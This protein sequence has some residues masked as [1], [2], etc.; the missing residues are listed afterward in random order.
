[1]PKS[2]SSKRRK[3]P[4]TEQ[5][6]CSDLKHSQR[7]ISTF[8]TSTKQRSNGIIVLDGQ[9]ASFHQYQR[10]SLK[11]GKNNSHSWFISQLKRFRANCSTALKLLDVGA[12]NGETFQKHSHWIDISCIDL[13]PQSVCVVK[14]DFMARPMPTSDSGKFHVVSLSLVVNFLPSNS[15][16]G[17]M[18]RRS[19]H[20]LLPGGLLYVVLPLHCITN[21]RY[22]THDHFTH[23]VT[24]GIGQFLLTDYRFSKKLAFYVFTHIPTSETTLEKT[25]NP[26][27]KRLLAEG[28]SMNNFC[29]TLD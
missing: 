29:I 24:E 5:R 21:S 28:P 4:V 26:Q 10:A 2:Q 14:Q 16:R 25:H 17:E 3:V 13:N 27:K 12:I 20:F 6:R 8:H 1:M 15:L 7:V 22:L 9:E 11:G 23:L 19:R 18:L